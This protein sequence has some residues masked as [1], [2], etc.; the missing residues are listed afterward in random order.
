MFIRSQDCLS[1]RMQSGPKDMH[2]FDV[3]VLYTK[4]AYWPALVENHQISSSN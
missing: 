1:L 3:L 2:S 4:M